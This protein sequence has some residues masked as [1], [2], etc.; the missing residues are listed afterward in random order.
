M[1]TETE[2]PTPNPAE[3]EPQGRVRLKRFAALMIPATLAG[4]ALVALTAQGVLAAQFSI[5]GIAF[6]VTADHLNGVGFEQWGAIDATDPS[7][8]NPNLSDTGGQVTVVVSAIHTAKLYNF[9][10]SVNLGAINLVL[11]AG[12]DVNHPVTGTDLVVDSDSLSG[13]A[14]FG[15]LEVGGDATQ[16]NDVPGIAAPKELA[17]DFGQQAKTVDIYN[18]KQNNY[19]TTAGAFSLPGLSMSFQSDGC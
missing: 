11:R 12:R 3:V 6:T 1:A 9:C 15:T 10:Q 2:T 13:D 17:G 8:G 5:S 16:L 4:G 18:L 14:S 19:A 7:N